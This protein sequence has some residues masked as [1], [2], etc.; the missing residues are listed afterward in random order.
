MVSTKAAGLRDRIVNR[1]F[2]ISLRD[3]LGGAQASLARLEESSGRLESRLSSIE[4]SLARAEAQQFVLSEKLDFVHRRLSVE[5]ERL[6]IERDDIDGLRDK[7]AEVRKT[8]EYSE[9]FLDREPLISVRIPAYKKTDELIDVAIASVLRQSYQRFEIVIVNDGPNDVTRNA[10]AKLG[11]ERIRYFEFDEQSRYPADAHSRWMVAGSPGMNRAAELARGTWIAP[12]DDDDAF[13]DDH[14]EKLLDVALSHGAELAYGAL[15][16]KNLL[17]GTERIVW[18]SPPAISEF[19]FMG[20]I[21]LRSLG[22]LRYDEQSWM[23]DEPGDWNLIRRMTAA[24]VVMA[25][26]KDIVGVINMLPY[27]AK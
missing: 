11:D 9:A 17:S 25:T 6:R 23:V 10:I 21:Y 3:S 7:L 20:A 26:T 2:G 12:L 27:T 19:S 8:S 14:L 16:Q 13:S 4:E 24:G 15:T 18:S 5:K 1:T 22:F